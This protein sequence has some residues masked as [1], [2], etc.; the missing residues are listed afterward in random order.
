M[1]RVSFIIA[2]FGVVVN[3]AAAQNVHV[4][5]DSMGWTIPPNTSVS[6]SNW[7]SAKTFIVGDILGNYLH[8]YLFIYYI[9]APL[10]GRP[11][12]VSVWGMAHKLFGA[13]EEI[14]TKTIYVDILFIFI[15]DIILCE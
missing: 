13:P 9:N 5:G 1:G 8:I 12:G 6:Y 4:V 7:A 14:K 2:I 11:G 3:F 10:R 15:I